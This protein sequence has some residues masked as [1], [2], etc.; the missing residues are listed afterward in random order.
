MEHYLDE[1][2]LV[3]ECFVY[4]TGEADNPIVTAAVYPCAEEMKLALEKRGLDADDE[5]GLKTILMELVRD[6]NKRFPNYKHIQKLIV[7]R[8]EFVKTTTRKIKRNDAQ[9]R[10][11]D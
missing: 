7:R 5:E 2:P 3:S 8:T 6:V 4:P 11:E 9:N 1:S 10:Q